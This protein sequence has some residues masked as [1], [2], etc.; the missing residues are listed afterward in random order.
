MTRTTETQ[1]RSFPYVLLCSTA[2]TIVSLAS[3]W[4]ATAVSYAPVIVA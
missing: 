1:D 2:A 3:V 4:I